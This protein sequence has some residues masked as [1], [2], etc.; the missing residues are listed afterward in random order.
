[1]VTPDVEMV[2]VNGV[3]RLTLIRPQKRNAVTAQMWHGMIRAIDE[4]S[5][6]SGVRALLIQGSGGSFCAGADLTEVRS[7]GGIQSADYHDLVLRGL[8]RIRDFPVVTV[9]LI[10]GPCV[11]AGCSIALACDIR[12][13]TL[14][15]YFAIPAVKFGFAFDEGGLRHLV[16]LVRS[17]HATR[18]MLAG[19]TIGSAEATTIGLVDHCS[20]GAEAECERFL[21]DLADANLHTAAE[22]RR[23]IRLFAGLDSEAHPPSHVAL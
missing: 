2:V 17:G 22:T 21:A 9:A 5:T 11:G 23:L 4:V 6:T 14:D 7:A 19:T 16:E 10:D 1:M 3:A 8:S 12:F 18:L 20:D 13:A 15:A